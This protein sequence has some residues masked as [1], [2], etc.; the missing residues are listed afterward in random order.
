MQHFFFNSAFDEFS[1]GA[2]SNLQSSY[3]SSPAHN[4]FYTGCIAY[5]WQ[6]LPMYPITY[7]YLSCK[8]FNESASPSNKLCHTVQHLNLEGPYGLFH[9]EPFNN[10]QSS[11]NQWRFYQVGFMRLEP[12]LR[13]YKKFIKYM[14]QRCQAMEWSFFHFV[15]SLRKKEEAN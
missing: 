14:C 15:C 7:H 9:N 11:F 13:F 6:V 5:L 8:G 4:D 10:L 2:H 1:N 12:T 3:K